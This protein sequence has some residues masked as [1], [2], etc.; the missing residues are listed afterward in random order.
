MRVLVV[1]DTDHVRSMLVDMLSLDGF[2]VV[3]QAADGSA[4]VTAVEE[5][6]PDVI[7]MDLR[8]PGVDGL[9]ATRRIRSR[10]PD[11]VVI[12]YTAYLDDRIKAEAAAAG[13]RLCLGKIE[14]LFE[15]ERELDRI[16]FEL[17]GEPER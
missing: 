17:T 10:R 13:A 12:L 4:A 11:Q 2:D 3:G 6:D 16:R 1:D 7:V 5:T 8:M 15:L 9:E 14:G